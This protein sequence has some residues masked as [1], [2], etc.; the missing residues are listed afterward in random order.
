MVTYRVDVSLSSFGEG[1]CGAPGC[2][3]W[4]NIHVT[5][6][7]VATIACGNGHVLAAATGL[8]RE[9]IRRNVVRFRVQAYAV[10]YER[11]E[12]I[13]ATSDQIDGPAT[14]SVGAG[15]CALPR[16]A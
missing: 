2:H 16:G 12:T 11:V 7:D 10:H 14:M 1:A 8:V 4:G 15:R 13:L 9:R 5:F 6:R 3:G